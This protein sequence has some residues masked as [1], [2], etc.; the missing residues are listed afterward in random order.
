MKNIALYIGIAL[1][2][3]GAVVGQLTG[4]E[5]AKWIEL[6]G[7]SAGLAA[8]IVGFVNDKA[9]KKDWKFWTAV[10]CIV[11]GT[12]A[13]IAAGIAKDTVTTI[14]STVAGVVALLTGIVS[15][16]FMSKGNTN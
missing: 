9:S 10:V 6:A 15:V 2:V 11:L 12:F 1:I 8:C 3:A 7:F 13:L 14:I 16:V 5:S 4:I